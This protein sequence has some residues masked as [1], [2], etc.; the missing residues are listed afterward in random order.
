MNARPDLEWDDADDDDSWAD[1]ADEG[2]D[3]AAEQQPA[4]PVRREHIDL[5]ARAESA[6]RGAGRAVQSGARKLRN[7]AEDAL[8]KVLP[9]RLPE[10][11]EPDAVRM[12]TISPA[13]QSLVIIALLLP[14]LVLFTVIMV[15][16]QHGRELEGRRGSLRATAVSEFDQAI[17]AGNPQL[18]A[19]GLARTL[20]LVEAGLAILPEDE[21]LVDL[22]RRATLKEDELNRVERLYHFKRLDSYTVGG[23]VPNEASRIVIHDK[24]AMVLN[25]GAGQVHGYTLSDVGDAVSSRAETQ[26]LLRTGEMRGAIEVGELVD[27]AWLAPTGSRTT[28]ELVTLD[29]EGTLW[30]LRNADV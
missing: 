22:R 9:D 27:M 28:G 5:S 19:D 13:S 16:V 20:E 3:E 25:K 10:R 4:T 29:R 18:Q 17:K 21:V 24:D 11:P 8:L 2:P 26:V 14:L 23:T 30:T 1:E 7:G 6:A 12:P 15:R